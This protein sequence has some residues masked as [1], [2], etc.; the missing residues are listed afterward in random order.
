MHYLIMSKPDIDA[1][2]DCDPEIPDFAAR[3]REMA[4]EAEEQLIEE[5]AE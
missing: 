1:I 4:E 5:F 2:C 3:V